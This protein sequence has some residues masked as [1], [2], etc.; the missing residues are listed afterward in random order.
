MTDNEFDMRL[1]DLRGSLRRVDKMF[2]AINILSR[3]TEASR[4]HLAD[5]M[6]AVANAAWCECQIAADLCE[7]LEK[8]AT[9][10]VDF[11]STYNLGFRDG[12]RNVLRGVQTRPSGDV[13]EPETVAELRKTVDAIRASTQADDGAT[14]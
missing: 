6:A 4:D 9:S 14:V 1:D 3:D 2:S 5:V 13:A 8:T 12:C 10:K 7:D 11:A